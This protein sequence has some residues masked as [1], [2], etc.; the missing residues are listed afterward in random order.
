MNQIRHVSFVEY[1]S[2]SA[3]VGGKV[4]GYFSLRWSFNPNPIACENRIEVKMRPLKVKKLKN[5]FAKPSVGG[6][7]NKCQH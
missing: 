1:Q 6:F 2:K 7:K 5:R 4:E 3:W